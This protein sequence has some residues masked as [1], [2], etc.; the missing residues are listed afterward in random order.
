MTHRKT[1]IW[2]LV[3][4][5]TIITIVFGLALYQIPAQKELLIAILA[6]V[7]NVVSCMA[8]IYI[9]KSKEDSISGT[10]GEK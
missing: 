5:A 7:S 4:I 2:G 10:N 1:I 9:G 3:W 8:G 6:V